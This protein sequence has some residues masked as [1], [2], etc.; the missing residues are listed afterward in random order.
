MWNHLSLVSIL[1][2]VCQCLFE[3]VTVKKNSETVEINKMNDNDKLL[4]FI[5]M[6]IYIYIYLYKTGMILKEP[7]SCP[8]KLATSGNRENKR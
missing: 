1:F 8:K 7:A 6:A 3:K 5:Y 4:K 2:S